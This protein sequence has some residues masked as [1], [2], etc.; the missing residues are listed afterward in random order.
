MIHFW[1]EAPGSLPSE[2]TRDQSH[3]IKTLYI[4]SSD[5][6]S[7][8]DCCYR[9]LCCFTNRTAMIICIVVVILHLGGMIAMITTGA[10]NSNSGLIGGAFGLLGGLIANLYNAWRIY[11]CGHLDSTAYYYTCCWFAPIWLTLSLGCEKGTVGD[12]YHFVDYQ[13]LEWSCMIDL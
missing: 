3:R 7:Q 6:I 2:M 12:E 11:K 5:S 1:Y 10:I 13:W 8:G 9:K 4:T